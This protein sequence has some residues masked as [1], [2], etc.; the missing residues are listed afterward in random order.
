MCEIHTTLRNFKDLGGL[1]DILPLSKE[2]EFTAKKVFRR[3][4]YVTCKCGCEMVHNGYNYAR[5]KGFGKV[6]LGKQICPK[7]REEYCEEKTF[8]KNLLSKWK[9]LVTSFLF[10]LRDSNVA[11]DV[12]QNVMSYILP[13]SKSKAKYLF[14]EMIDQFEYAQENYLI[15]NYDEQH[16]KRG[17]HQ[18]Y[19]LTLLNYK[20]GVPVAEKL[21]DN[22][23]R[24][25]IKKFL[26]EHLDVNKKL[27]IITDCDQMYPPLFK[28]IWGN[29]II[30]QM[31]LLHLNKLI[32]KD[33]GK[34]TT[35][36]NEYNK[37][38]LLNIFYNRNRELR[39]LRKLLSKQ[40]NKVFSSKQEKQE[41]VIE[42]KKKFYEFVREG[43][44]SRRR[45]KKNLTQR[46]LWKAIGIFHRL[47]FENF[48]FSKK[49][50]N[51]LDMIEKNWKYF[52]SFYHVKGCPATN[53]A[54]ENYYST[55]LKT[56]R[57][58]QLRTDYGLVN[59]MKL[60]AYKRMYGFN[61]PRKTFIEIHRI[62]QLVDS[63]S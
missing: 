9:E 12:I 8:W 41:W 16:P 58:K 35:L 36:E 24:E 57:K 59:H 17:R 28:E 48:L 55:S 50:K 63:D 26:I 1:V 27:I 4:C 56:H 10:V 37:Y 45:N 29:K 3:K 52:T 61:E 7:C 19:R 46:K 20:T 40:T 5:K 44:K 30:H 14:D 42:V 25:T 33:F 34:Y 13:C 23:E 62:F 53:N 43:E 31:C 2:H 38:S 49:I 6:R 21:F 54:I 18:K 51:R 15:V 39:Y 47:K 22:K 60:S 11:W 32:V